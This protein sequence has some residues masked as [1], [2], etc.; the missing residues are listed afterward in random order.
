MKVNLFIVRHGHSPFIGQD[1][2]S[3]PL[4]SE[5]E[6][7]ALNVVFITKHITK[8]RTKL[9]TSAAQRTVTTTENI[10]ES[11]P[12][13]QV[14]KNPKLYTASVGDWCQAISEH[15]TENLILVGHNPTVSQLYQYLTQSDPQ[16]FTPATT[17]HLILDIASDGLTLPAQAQQIYY[18]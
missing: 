10:T 4:S 16:G 14:I 7:Q 6:Q 2:F 18:P 5:G 13:A 3:R 1:D 8:G 15:A 17:G 12:A 11:L 9:I